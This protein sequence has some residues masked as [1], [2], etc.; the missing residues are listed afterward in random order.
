MPAKLIALKPADVSERLTSGT[1]VLIDIREAD[2]FARNHIV[3]ALSRPLSGFEKAHLGI[4]AGKDAIFT[5]RTGMRTGANCGR[6][7]ARVN[8]EAFVLDGGIENWTK[9]GLPVAN[10]PGAP[11]EM[12]RQVQITAGVLVL[13]GVGLGL[14]VHPG[15]FGL[16]AFVGAGLT[17]A[18]ISGFCGMARLLALMPWNRLAPA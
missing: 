17:F 7:A 3:G 16:A 12:M 13:I 1:A 8:G 5:C 9:S 11:L 4:A 6:L 18:G 10:N 14:V 2:E 15:F